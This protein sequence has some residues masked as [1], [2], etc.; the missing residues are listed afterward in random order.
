MRKLINIAQDALKHIKEE[1]RH[2]VYVCDT[3]EHNWHNAC[4]KCGC[5]ITSKAA[6]PTAACPLGR[7]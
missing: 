7:W 2:R 3:C 5:F 4:K 6:I 1:Y